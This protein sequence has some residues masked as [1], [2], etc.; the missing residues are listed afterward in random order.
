M[1]TITII[2]LSLFL[3]I[4]APVSAQ[5]WSVLD[6]GA[7]GDGVAKDTEA[8]Q[9]AVD[10]AHAAGGGKVVLP[11][12]EYLSGSVY[13]KN[14][15]ELHL[16]EG[17]VLKGSPDLEDY[18]PSD[19]FPQNYS[20]PRTSENISGGH[21][22][23]GVG[24]RNVTLSGPG[25]I[26]GNSRHFFLHGNYVDVGKKVTLPDRP[27]Q[28]IW[29]ADCKN[30]RIKDLEIAQAPYWSC[31][32]INC[33]YVWITG[34]KVHTER[35]EYVTYN[36]DGIDID[37]C[38]FVHISDCHIDTHDDCI[39]LRASGAERFANPQNCEFVTVNG[40][41]LSS[42]CNAIRLGVGEG[43]VREAVFSNLVIY[44]SQTAFNLVSGYSR[45]ECG[46]SMEGI[47]FSNIRVEAERLMKIHHMRGE[48][49]FRDI[50]FED[51]SGNVTATSQ[52]W[53]KK[54]LPFENITFRNVKVVGRYERI[55]ADVRADGGTFLRQRL[56]FKIV[57][58]RKANIEN[59]KK[60]LY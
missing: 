35:E 19:C 31:F 47:R 44:N 32:L 48:G 33:E 36:G 17:A 59:E 30:I 2:S 1:R 25:K 11:A 6:Y 37:R 3:A 45:D 26:D 43:L 24:L 50:A 28:M 7:K 10:A 42:A 41:T 16:A 9:A 57:R 53:A 13:L 20:S 56:P 12:G 38:R 22:I 34:C 23:L 8:I 54:A 21:L 27:G 40:C 49:K 29:F 39:T 5:V 58:T 60:L 52:I 46:A 18:C 14:N 4:A 55:N 51:I 15:I